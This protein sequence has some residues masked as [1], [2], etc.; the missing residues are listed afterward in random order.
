MTHRSIAGGGRLAAVTATAALT[1][2]LALPTATALA[3]PADPHPVAGPAKP[4]G[5]IESSL[6]VLGTGALAAASTAVIL[7]RHQRRNRHR[8]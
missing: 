1:V 7:R 6:S 2:A 5:P 3:A 8:R 4:E